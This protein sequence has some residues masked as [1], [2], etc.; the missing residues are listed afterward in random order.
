MGLGLL[1]IEYPRFH[2]FD[3]QVGAKLRPGVRGH[4][5]EEGGGYV[6][7]NSEGFR[8]KEHAHKKPPNTLRIAVLG[9]CYAEAM[10]VNMEETF[11]A[12]MERNL[13]GCKDLQGR[14]VEVINF[15]ISGYGTTQELLALRKWVWKYS[16]DVILLAFVTGN[17]IADNSPVL[18]Q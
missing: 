15:G 16:P 5:L 2:E 3:P 12:V 1:R 10:Q 17:D 8:D 11:W 18:M 9:D 7:I 14:Q 6:S 13:Q 4:W